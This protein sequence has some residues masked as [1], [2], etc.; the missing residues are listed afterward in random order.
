MNLA[1]FLPLVAATENALMARLAG[2]EEAIAD[3]IADL[4]PHHLCY[5]LRD[6]AA[7]FHS[8]YNAERVLVDDPALRDARLGLLIATR[9]VLRNGLG[10]L[11]VSAPQ[12]M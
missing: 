8:F 2:F 10:L 6:L 5:Y 7:D 11:G 4:S 12:R 3:V 9:T 1:R